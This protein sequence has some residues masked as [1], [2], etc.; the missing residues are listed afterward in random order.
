MLGGEVYVAVPA[1]EAHD[2]PFLALAPIAPA[3]HAAGEFDRQIVV[4]P[5]PAFAD[6]LGLGGTDLFLQFSQS[7][8]ARGLA[9]VDP[10]LRH[11]PCRHCRHVA[12]AGD[13]HLSAAD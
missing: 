11:L 10:A 4:Q 9:R 8:L 1:G 13:E 6:D 7:R 2:K 5:T 3:P 12:A